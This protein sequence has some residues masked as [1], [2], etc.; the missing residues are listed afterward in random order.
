MFTAI[1]EEVVEK[2]RKI[3]DDT[4]SLK[5]LTKSFLTP[6]SGKLTLGVIPTI[7]ALSRRRCITFASKHLPSLS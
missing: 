7:A 5:E 4:L 6:L 3:I 1:G 2:A